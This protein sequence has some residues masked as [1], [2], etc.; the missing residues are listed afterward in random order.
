[1]IEQG[2]GM[3]LAL[4]M[5]SVLFSMASSRIV[6]LIEVMALQGILVALL[7]ML[8]H[9]TFI[10]NGTLIFEGVVLLIKG[11]LIPY[12]LFF[13]VKHAHIGR[14]IEPIVGYHAS[15]FIGLLLMLVAFFIAGHSALPNSIHPLLLPTAMTTVASGLFL[16]VSRRKAITMVIGYLIME[17]GIFLMGM[18]L[19]GE[20]KHLV[21]L[22]VLLDLLVGVMIMGIV[23]NHIN[24]EFDHIDTSLLSELKDE[25]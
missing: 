12:L 9:G 4:V 22:G 13:A 24:Q 25:S 2:T 15:I 20:M 8:L 7:P 23:L 18:M 16:I 1:M 21:E 6:V 10:I 14:E 5:L 11:V 19:A 3:I 17:N